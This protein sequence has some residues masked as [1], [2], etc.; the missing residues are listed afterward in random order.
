MLQ[1][2][3]KKLHLDAKLPKKSFPTDSGADLYSLI[4]YLLMP[5]QVALIDTGI[6]IE[7]PEGHEAQIRSRSGLAAKSKIHVLNSPG[8]IDQT[9][10]GNIKVILHNDSESDFKISK[11]IVLL[12]W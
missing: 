4:D 12:K 3:V 1:V 5:N 10:T 6:A 8:T 2:K 7:L 11:G 9:F